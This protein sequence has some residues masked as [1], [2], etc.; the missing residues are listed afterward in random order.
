MA[1][2]PCSSTLKEHSDSE[3]RLMMD[4]RPARLEEAREL[5]ELCLRSKSVWGYDAAI[6]E[7]CR[8]E[9]TI[10]ARDFERSA[11]YVAVEKEKIVGIAQTGVDGID[12]YLHKLFID[13][14]TIGNRAGR[15]LFWSV[16]IARQKG[17]R[18]LWIEA[19]P[20]AA[21]FYRKMGAIDDG[22]VPSQSVLGRVLPRLR[23]DI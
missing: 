14:A 5:T 11:L 15:R 12:A 18:H 9:L 1:G 2:A 22:V 20:D 3:F 10:S 4:L 21:G 6:M 13:P 19:Q 8:D 7:A 17:A 16:A 23:T